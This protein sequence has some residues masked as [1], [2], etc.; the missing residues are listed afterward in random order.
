KRFEQLD[1]IIKL[2]GFLERGRGFC[3]QQRA[4]AF[5][6]RELLQP[7]AFKPKPL[8]HSRFR[9]RRELAKASNA[10]KLERL[11]YLRR[12][13]GFD[14]GQSPVQRRERQITKVFG[15]FAGGDNRDAGEA[16]CRVNGRIGILRH[17]YVDFEIQLRSVARD[18]FCDIARRA[19]Q[20]LAAF[21]VEDNRVLRG[22]FHH[23]RER[24]G[25][26]HQRPS[27]L[28]IGAINARE[29]DRSRF[30][31]PYYIRKLIKNIRK[32]FKITKQVQIAFAFSRGALIDMLF[33]R[34]NRVAMRDTGSSFRNIIDELLNFYG[35][36]ES[37]GVTDPLGMILLENVAYLVGDERRTQAFNALRERV[38]LTPPEI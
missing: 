35:P 23:R 21:D 12:A 4:I 22:L 24:V 20:Q 7:H 9:Q 26:I 29:H 6:A 15:F 19:E 16:S 31:P 18:L 11:Q 3:E 8:G 33:C 5:A 28:K 17:G 36:P 13:I 32:Y 25:A 38:G 30:E 14:A 2:D 10:P 37:P 27:T 34:D 1:G